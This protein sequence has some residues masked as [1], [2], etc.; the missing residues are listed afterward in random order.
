MLVNDAF[1]LTNFKGLK[2]IEGELGMDKF[3]GVNLKVSQINCPLLQDFGTEPF[4]FGNAVLAPNSKNEAGGLKSKLRG[5]AGFGL[6]SQH[7]NVAFEFYYSLITFGQ[8]SEKKSTFQI[9]L[10]ID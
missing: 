8:N 3:L 6:S 7:L 10:G 4:I 1:Y 9:N 2:N 5:S